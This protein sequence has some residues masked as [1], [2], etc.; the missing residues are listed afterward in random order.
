MRSFNFSRPT[1]PYNAWP[2]LMGA[3]LASVRETDVANETDN[4]YYHI[5]I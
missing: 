4:D 2:V 1:V 5:E 3:N